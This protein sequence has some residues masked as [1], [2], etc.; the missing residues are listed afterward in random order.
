M[1]KTVEL[2]RKKRLYRGRKEREERDR[3]KLQTYRKDKE[4]ELLLEENLN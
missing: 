3:F 2:N 4:E 1:Y